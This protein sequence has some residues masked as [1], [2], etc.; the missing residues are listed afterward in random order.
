MSDESCYYSPGEVPEDE[1][2]NGGGNGDGLLAR[3]LLMDFQDVELKKETASNKSTASNREPMKVFLRIRPFTAQETKAS[4]D[5]GC[6]KTLDEKTIILSAPSDSFTFKSSIRGIAEQTHQFSFTKVYDDNTTQKDIFDDSMLA[7]VKDFL[8]GI[9]CLIFTY[10]V[11]NSG[12]VDNKI[13]T[14][15]CFGGIY[16]CFLFR[17]CRPTRK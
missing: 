10:G 7:I 4:E 8:D 15:L 6:L 13:C 2:E 5:Q 11:T 12:K 14:A 16:F 17:F 1:K 3:N 9:N